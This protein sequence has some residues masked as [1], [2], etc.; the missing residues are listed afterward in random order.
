MHIMSEEEKPISNSNGGGPK[1]RPKAIATPVE[2]GIDYRFARVVM[3]VVP[4]AKHHEAE[5]IY[6][7]SQGYALFSKIKRIQSHRGSRHRDTEDDEIHTLPTIGDAFFVS[8][9]HKT[10]LP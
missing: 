1:I 7:P 5:A 3:P 4:D 2:E 10:D 9:L 6:E 8:L